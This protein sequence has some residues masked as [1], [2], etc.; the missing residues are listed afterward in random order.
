RCIEDFNLVITQITKNSVC[1]QNKLFYE[2]VI[3]LSGKT[4]EIPNLNDF[5]L[6]FIENE[7]FND[8]EIV[9]N[10]NIENDCQDLIY[11]R[12]LHDDY[13]LACKACQNP[14]Y[15]AKIVGYINQMFLVKLNHNI[16]QK[17]AS[18]LC[19]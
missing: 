14:I 1:Q 12:R 5:I 15:D 3:D 4:G 19:L 18:I 7:R 2:D 8:D 6:S 16:L 11:L 17:I 13:I 10:K 9:T